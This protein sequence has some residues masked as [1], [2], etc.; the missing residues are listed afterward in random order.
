VTHH[1]DVQ[2]GN[3]VKAGMGAGNVWPFSPRC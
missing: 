2:T 3:A 1:P